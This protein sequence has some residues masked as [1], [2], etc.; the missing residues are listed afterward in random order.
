MRYNYTYN[1]IMQAFENKL[2]T[3]I[4]DKLELSMDYKISKFTIY[5]V[6]CNNIEI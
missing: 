3:I 4:Q 5:N 2:K 1:I 6:K